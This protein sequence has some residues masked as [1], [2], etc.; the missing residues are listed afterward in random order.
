VGLN[1]VLSWPTNSPGFTLQ[2]TTNLLSAAWST[3]SGAVVLDGQNTV[4]NPLSGTERFFRL[5]Q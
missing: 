4:T 1:V 2:S 5:F 3:V